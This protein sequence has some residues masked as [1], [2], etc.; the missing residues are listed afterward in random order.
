[1]DFE[2]IIEYFTRWK[3][4][5]LLNEHQSL[6]VHANYTSLVLF[7]LLMLFVPFLLSFLLKEWMCMLFS[8]IIVCFILGYIFCTKPLNCFLMKDGLEY[9]TLLFKKKKRISFLD[10]QSVLIYKNVMQFQFDNDSISIGSSWIHYKEIIPFVKDAFP[11]ICTEYDNEESKTKYNDE[12]EFIHSIRTETSE[13][14]QLYKLYYLVVK[15]GK[16][17][18]EGLKFLKEIF[19]NKYLRSIDEAIIL[20]ENKVSNY[21]EN[22]TP[23]YRVICNLI[24]ESKK[25]RYDQRLDLLNGLFEV[26]YKANR[27]SKDR[28][29]ILRE[30]ARFLLI[31]EY[32]RVSL[33]YMY[34]YD[35]LFDPQF[36][37]MADKLEDAYK[38]LALSETASNQQIKSNYRCLAK[39]YHPDKLTMSNSE[40][41]KSYAEAKFRAITE[42]Y[43]LL[44][45]VRDIK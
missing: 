8:F 39:K 26:A 23:N 2:K 13:L 11:S 31:N 14:F 42:A 19:R 29:L 22:K 35:K 27:L 45:K 12:I 10:L 20:F 25:M 33:E 7:I 4:Q 43:E 24:I 1:M 5:G 21:D 44:C 15:D 37:M 28:L 18:E 3:D 30:I 36:N 9:Q 16:Y 6:H 34:G 32:D 41:E 17:E 40:E 38:V